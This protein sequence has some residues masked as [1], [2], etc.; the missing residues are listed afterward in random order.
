MLLK[1]DEDL[2]VKY[3][4]LLTFASQLKA[5][6]GLTIIGTAIQGNFL[7]SYGEAQAA[8]QVGPGQRFCAIFRQ[9]WPFL[10]SQIKASVRK[11]ALCVSRSILANM[12][13]ELLLNL[14]YFLILPFF[15]RTQGNNN[16][17]R[18]GESN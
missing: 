6:K 12:V 14:Q 11:A 9:S 8:E 16:H 2:H 1:L 5:G 3:P 7:E 18:Q 17:M 4:R 10:R 13:H 15:Q